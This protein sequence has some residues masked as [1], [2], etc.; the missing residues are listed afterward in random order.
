[1]R[2]HHLD[3]CTMCPYPERLVHGRGSMLRRGRMVAH[4][5]LLET[6]SSGL[7]LV[8]AGIGLED[9][10]APGA[11]L[12]RGFV[13]MTGLVEPRAEMSA[14][15]QV[16][17]LG[18]LPRD[19]RHVLVTHL[20]LDHAGGLADFPWAKVHV[21]VDERDAAVERPTLRERSRYRPVHF[22]HH[23]DWATYAQTGEPWKGF[24]AVR[25][26][27]GLPPEF[28]AIPLPGHTRGH[29]CIAVDTGSRWLLHAG[30]A[31]FSRGALDGRG[32][33]L[34]LAFFEQGVAIDRERVRENH[35]R[36]G[37]L[38]RAHAADVRVF[39][40]HDCD[41]FDALRAERKLS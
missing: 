35:A 36:L 29:A 9:I 1:M 37:E 6:D 40:A 8:D 25:S 10:A 19:V 23:P 30:D 41:E 21:H 20:D 13:A 17:A 39:S 33:P 34:G 11:R 18:F 14:I 2:V 5:L 15:E 28:L 24:A 32:T 16:K 3:C 26:L 27:P 4:C 31:Y 22:A 38:A 12:G 7:V